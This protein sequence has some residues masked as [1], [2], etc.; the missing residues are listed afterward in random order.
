MAEGVGEDCKELEGVAEAEGGEG[1]RAAA[2][3]GVSV[4]VSGAVG[5][6]VG[7]GGWVAVCE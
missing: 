1:E 4:V 3:D 5:V 6:A 2:C 7:E